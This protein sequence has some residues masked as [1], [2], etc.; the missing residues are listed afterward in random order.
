MLLHTLL[1]TTLNLG[2]H[3]DVIDEQ[4]TNLHIGH[5]GRIGTWV[6]IILSGTNVLKQL[7]GT[8][9]L[10]INKTL[11]IRNGHGWNSKTGVLVKPEEQGNPEINSGLY[12]LRGLRTIAKSN[13]CADTSTTT[14]TRVNISRLGNFLSGISIPTD[15]L[16]RCNE[17][18][19]PFRNLNF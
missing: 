1:E 14:R 19:L 3:E 6:I 10:N 5:W 15:L 4:L 17:T 16:V 12:L 7:T 8:S 2:V 11:T 18:F 13:L 9:K